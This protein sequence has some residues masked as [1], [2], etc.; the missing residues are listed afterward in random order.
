MRRPKIKIAV[1]ADEYSALKGLALT[2]I[3]YMTGNPRFLSP[4]P[5]MAELNAALVTLTNCIATWGEP[6]NYGSKLDLTR[7]RGAAINMHNLLIKEAAYVMNQVDMSAG[8][9][10]QA[11]FIASSGFPVANAPNPQGKLEKVQNFHH[12]V[13][14]KESAYDVKLKWEKPLNVSVNT[15]V[16]VYLIYKSATPDFKDA[17]FMSLS[18]KT[19]F[20]DYNPVRGAY[21]YYFVMPF[22][23][24]G[25]GVL[26]E[27][28]T[29]S[30]PA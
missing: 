8:V 1:T 16:K 2:V 6:G 18:T 25:M 29:V 23:N 28:V 24:A 3:E 21:N 9:E 22:N 5:T 10:E 20:I 11:V 13:S 17:V 12:F 30:V 4:S 7:L 27:M 14:R 26:S 15:N 19:S